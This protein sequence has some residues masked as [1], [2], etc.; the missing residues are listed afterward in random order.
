MYRQIRAVTE[1]ETRLAV[2]LMSGTSLDGVDAAL[3]LITG[4]GADTS[5]EL[6]G[7]SVLPFTPSEQE[8]LRRLCTPGVGTVDEVCE[9]N[10][11]LG[12][13]FA[14]AA[15]HVTTSSG[16][17]MDD[18]DFISS[19]GQTVQHMPACG[20]TLQIGEL[21]VIAARTGRLTVGDFRPADMAL[22][23]QGAP[24]VPFVD[25]LLFS[26]A[27]QS[28]AML[29]IGGI[30]NV[31]VLPAG[32][33]G[34]LAFDTGPGN[35]LIDAVVLAL[36]GGDQAFDRDGLIARAGQVNRRL[37]D[38]WLTAD[39]FLYLSPPKST[40]REHYTDSM[41][42]RLICE[43]QALGITMPDIVATVSAYTYESIA[44]QFSLHVEPFL[45]TPVEAM[46]VGGGGAHNPVLMDGLR[47]TL[48]IPVNPM[49][50]IG[51]STDAKEAV[52]FVV[53]G[54]EFLFGNHNSLHSVTGASSPA[55][56]GKLVLPPC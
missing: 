49:E 25:K 10:V 23:G 36:T 56:M 11:V 16:Y 4:S 53:L 9:L 35:V 39:D 28:R 30:A 21:A 3:V 15:L 50:D 14:A 26:S 2:G 18:V 43:A 27:D 46:W 12:E 48:K 13:R 19:H 6:A 29:N 31:T 45:M 33:G 8:R 5:V 44:L 1:K 54:N 37:L 7:F 22:G 17:T 24:L 20:A 34:V 42:A 51:F 40:G 32:R 41:A 52:A 38:I 47:R 55:I